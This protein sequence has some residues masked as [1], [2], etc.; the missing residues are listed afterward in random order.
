MVKFAKFNPL[1]DENN[2]AL[3]NAYF[4]VNETKKVEEKPIENPG[5]P[6]ENEEDGV[7]E[8]VLK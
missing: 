3:V 4:F 8:V 6:D 5:K 7:E 2:M 1:P